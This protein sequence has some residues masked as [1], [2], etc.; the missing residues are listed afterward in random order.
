MQVYDCDLIGDLIGWLLSLFTTKPIPDA[1]HE[2]YNFIEISLN[3]STKKSAIFDQ[4][5]MC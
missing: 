1:I 4:A 2:K 5:S 3:M